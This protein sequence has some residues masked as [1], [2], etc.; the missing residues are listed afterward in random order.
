[1][2]NTQEDFDAWE[3]W[4]NSRMRLLIKARLLAGA[5]R[6][7]MLLDACVVVPCPCT[8]RMLGKGCL[9]EIAH[10]LLLALGNGISLLLGQ[11]PELASLCRACC[12]RAC[13]VRG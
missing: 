2:A 3:G 4:V 7:A 6:W 9:G 8:S 13:R 11:S 5:A 12:L 1:M 10:G